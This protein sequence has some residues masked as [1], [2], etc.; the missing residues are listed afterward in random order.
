MYVYGGEMLLFCHAE[1]GLFFLLLV[2]NVLGRKENRQG[3]FLSPSFTVSQLSTQLAGMQQ[4][5]QYQVDM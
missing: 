3:R 1:T 2:H 5:L 4:Y